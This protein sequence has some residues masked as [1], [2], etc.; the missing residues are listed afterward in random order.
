MVTDPPFVMIGISITVGAFAIF[1][2]V[3]V[4]I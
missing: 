1:I 4:S 3:L 2:G